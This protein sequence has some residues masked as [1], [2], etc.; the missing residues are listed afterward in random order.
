[1]IETA[2]D[3][4]V[5]EAEQKFS[6]AVDQPLI[7]D[8]QIDMAEEIRDCANRVVEEFPGEV[9]T[10][11]PSLI[12]PL[13][14]F[15]ELRLIGSEDALPVRFV[16]LNFLYRLAHF[17]GFSSE[18]SATELHSVVWP[19]LERFVRLQELSVVDDPRSLRWE[20]T[21]AGVIQ[22]WDRAMSLIN[23]LKSLGAINES[24][25]RALKGQIYVCSVVA[26]RHEAR[27]E[28]EEGQ[29]EKNFPGSWVPRMDR[30]YFPQGDFGSWIR[31]LGLLAWGMTLTDAPEYSAWE[32]ER[33]SDAAHE[34]DVCM[35]D[36]PDLLGAYRAAWGKC[37]FLDGD[38]LRAAKHF[39]TLVVHGCGL[40]SEMEAAFRPRLY[41]NVAECFGK[42]GETQ[43]AIERLEA[44][45][46]EFPRTG[47]VWLKLAEIYLSSPL[48]L[49]LQKVKECLRREEEIDPNF[50]RDPRAS[51]ALILAELV[52]R[53]T[54]S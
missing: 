8:A 43:S 41:P 50:G 20:I 12:E 23:R 28:G 14:E 38:Y 31:P 17:T 45:A 18:S 2:F 42:G 36:S 47:G 7:D 19:H 49:D 44:C 16:I 39:D 37:H 29:V 54:G 35:E 4:W 6:L 27:D 5:R 26:A 11:V 46:Q 32:R 24:E 52:S 53:P 15:F 33:L 9:S 22:D 34:W 13:I 3:A 48:D 10:S 1:M 30:A 25:G 21:N 40:P 51:I